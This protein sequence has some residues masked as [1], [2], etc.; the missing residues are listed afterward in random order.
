[1]GHLGNRE[2]EEGCPICFYPIGEKG[3]KGPVLNLNCGHKFHRNCLCEWREVLLFFFCRKRT[4][5]LFYT[6]LWRDNFRR[7][8]PVRAA[9]GQSRR[10][11]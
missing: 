5:L 7:R 4:K 8:R 10:E 11:V 3:E 2:S 6:V 1:M 9:I